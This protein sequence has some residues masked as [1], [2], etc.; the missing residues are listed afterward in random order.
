MKND[1]FTMTDAVPQIAYVYEQN[2]TIG[3][4]KERTASKITRSVSE[5]SGISDEKVSIRYV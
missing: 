5:S 2:D 1:S 4:T 3:V